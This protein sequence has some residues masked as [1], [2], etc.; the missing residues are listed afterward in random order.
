MGSILGS[1]VGESDL[2]HIFSLTTLNG[3]KQQEKKV[4]HIDEEAP[5]LILALSS[6]PS[7]ST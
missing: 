5:R 7:L 6:V 2:K 3:E 1:E 4:S